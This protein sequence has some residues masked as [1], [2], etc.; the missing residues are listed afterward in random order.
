MAFSS[1][2]NANLT[3][4]G[5]MRIAAVALTPAVVLSTI[6]MVTGVSFPGEWLVY[7]GLELLFLFI[8][9]KANSMPPAYGGPGAYPYAAGQ[10]PQ[11]PY[12]PPGY[13]P[14]AGGYPAQPQGYPPQPPAYPTAP[15]YP[16]QP[17]PPPP[18]YQR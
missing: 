1:A 11:Q 6:L 16:P 14:Q 2:F 8:G 18:G 17:P 9:V 4:G 10:Y 3:F 12:A 7:L 5:A 13:P 15:A